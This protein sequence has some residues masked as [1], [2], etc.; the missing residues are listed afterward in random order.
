MAA[1]RVTTRHIKR[2]TQKTQCLGARRMDLGHQR[3]TAQYDNKG[4]SP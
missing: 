2:A 4:M 3:V 1:N